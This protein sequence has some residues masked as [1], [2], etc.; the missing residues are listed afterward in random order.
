LHDI[1]NEPSCICRRFLDQREIHFGYKIASGDKSR[2]EPGGLERTE[3]Q[4]GRLL[5][6]S[7]FHPGAVFPAG[8]FS[9]IEARVC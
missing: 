5:T 9:V 6:E 3:Q 7:G 2:I 1:E 8:R 4:Y